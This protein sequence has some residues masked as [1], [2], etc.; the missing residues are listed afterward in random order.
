[1]SIT[2]KPKMKSS[3]DNQPQTARGGPAHEEIE[4][5]AYQIYLER[6]GA[7]GQDVDDWLQAE[8]GLIEKNEKTTTSKAKAVA[9]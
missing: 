9:T 7:L 1:M 2:S 6:G 4:I 3:E 8:R 5:R